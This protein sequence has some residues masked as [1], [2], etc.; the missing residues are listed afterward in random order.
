M[1]VAKAAWALW[2]VVPVLGWAVESGDFHWKGRIDAEKTVVIRGMNGSVEVAGVEGDE[3]EVSASKH[4]PNAEFMTVKVL[5]TAE[6]LLVCETYE[7]NGDASDT[8]SES[9][10]SHSR[11]QMPQVDYT[12]RIPRN[13]KLRAGSVNGSVSAERLGRYAEVSSVNGSVNV[14]TAQWAKASSVNGSVTA[15]F[16]KADWQDLKLSTVNGSI[17]LSLPAETSTDIR[18]HSVNGHFESDFPVT[19]QGRFGRSSMEGRIGQGGRELDLNTV[20]GNVEIRKT[21]M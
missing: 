20:N 10:H 7:H 1:R 14:S 3:V 5:P 4:G 12:V 8:C 18:F 21:T 19:V 6:G 13:L 15:T 2:L 17:E 11:G 9:T 16:G